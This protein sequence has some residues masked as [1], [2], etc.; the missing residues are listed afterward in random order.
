MVHV[1][2]IAASLRNAR[3]GAGNHAL[4]EDL[5]HLKDKDALHAYL[6]QQAKIRT[7][8]FVSAGSKDGKPFNEIYNDLQ[9]MKGDRGLSNSEASLAAGL[10]GAI[11]EGAT[12]DHVGL[13]P[14]FPPFKEP[15]NT[16]ELKSLILKADAILLSGPVYFGDRGSLAHEF[17]EFLHNDP[18][19]TAH[20]R[21]KVYAGIAVGAK[22]NGG[23]ETTLIF[24][25]VD[26]TNMNMLAVGNDS[27]TTSQYGGTTVAGDIGTLAEDKYGIDTCIGTGRRVARVSRML[28][29][30]Q[31]RRLKDKLTIDIW[32]LQDQKDHYGRNVI[33]ALLKD[34]SINN[35][36]V[37]FR[38]KDLTEETIMR[39][40]ACDICPTHLGPVDDYRCIITSD[41]DLFKRDHAD[42]ISADA[43][44]M[45]VYSP[46]D[47][48]QINSVYQRFI[49]RTRYWR[50]DDY[51]IGDRLA[52]PMVISQLNANQNMHIRMM[53][54]EVRHHTV[55]HH[56]LIGMELDGN[57][58]NRD[59]LLGQ[60]DS[61]VGNAV[62]LTI[63][64]LQEGVGANNRYNDVGYII[65]AAKAVG[66]VPE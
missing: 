35:P 44:I 48:G 42:L 58:L 56:S 33:E 43:V 36:H 14:F 5:K 45:A 29:A 51:A 39:C 65:S 19:L 16:D 59:F 26:A 25:I 18:E 27:Q 8:D 12:V 50:H 3:F 30:A 61:F 4:V 32:L 53:T 38:L 15:R 37:S 62:N 28:A 21:N 10:W 13:T 66:D 49:E 54:S 1:L 57:L 17:M 7:E 11:Q 22:R 47:R 55:L 2:G 20:L 34:A 6:E 41:K 9:K 63:G 23:Q 24:Q 31:G 40:I 60:I 46:I 52:A 64:R